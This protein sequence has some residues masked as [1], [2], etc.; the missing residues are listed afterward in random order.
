MHRLSRYLLRNKP[1]RGDA[2]TSKLCP[3]AFSPVFNQLTLWI[4]SSSAGHPH[5]TTSPKP[6]SHFTSYILF[7][8]NMFSPAFNLNLLT[9][10]ALLVNIVAFLGGRAYAAPTPVTRSTNL[11]HRTVKAVAS[12]V[13]LCYGMQQGISIPMV[14]VCDSVHELWGSGM[15]PQ[16]GLELLSGGSKDR[17]CTRIVPKKGS[18]DTNR[19]ARYCAFKTGPLMLAVS[20]L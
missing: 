7:A 20:H 4:P 18:A 17:Q 14:V 5:R 19:T 3:V 6:N 8:L 10:F 1:A 2:R 16:L 11:A 12:N 15:G 9:S 13:P